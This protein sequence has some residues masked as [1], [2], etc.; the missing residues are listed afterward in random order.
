MANVLAQ[1]L[2]EYTESN[3]DK[4]I[5]EIVA[6]SKTPQIMAIQTGIKFKEEVGRM[7]TDVVFQD[8][9]GCG[10]TPNGTTYID[11]RTLT[12]GQIK[13]QENICPDDLTQSYL[14]SKLGKGSDNRTL[15]FEQVYTDLKVKKI[16]YANE[17]AIWQ[18]DTDSTDANLNKFDGF[19]KIIDA[20]ADV[21]HGNT[22]SVTSYD[23][24]NAVSVMDAMDAAIPTQL[25][26]ADGTRPIAI[27]CGLDWFSTYALALR[28][29]NLFHYDGKAMNYEIIIPGST[30][31]LIGLDGLTGTDRMVAG[32]IGGEGNFV[33]GTDL[34]NEQEKF[35][36]FWSEDDE[37]LK[38]DAKWKLGTQ[39]RVP[40][41]LVEFT[42]SA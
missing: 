1:N 4:L 27:L 33:I 3:K 9:A 21:V 2:S 7:K 34:K 13:V 40:E 28:N 42:L 5:A 29:A 23:A 38:F 22:G 11:T 41:E 15:P 31:K 12:V 6:G 37:V 36:M 18:G 24:S 19:L 8:G 35:R 10:R 14:A 20:E 25:K 26:T 39:I 17:I 32:V 30:T 16:T